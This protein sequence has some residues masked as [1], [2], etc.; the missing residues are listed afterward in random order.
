MLRRPSVFAA[1]CTWA[2]ATAALAG[3]RAERLLRIT[4]DPPAAGVWVD[5]SYRGTTPL[6]LPFEHYGTRRVTYRLEGHGTA[7]LRVVVAPPWYARFPVD[8]FSEVLMPVGWRDEHSVHVVLRASSDELSVPM[9][10]SV[11]DRAEALRR[12]GPRGPGPL[13]PIVESEPKAPEPKTPERP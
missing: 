9:I 1:A 3:C 4:S 13:P 10:R 12:A 11:L 8:L 7:S 2:A 5:D 6:D